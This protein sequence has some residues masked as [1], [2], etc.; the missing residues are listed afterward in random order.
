M[1][2]LVVLALGISLSFS[3]LADAQ[4]TTAPLRGNFLWIQMPHQ[5]QFAENYPQNALK[6]H[7]A[8]SATLDCRVG[9]DEHRH[10]GIGLACTML[11]ETPEGMGFGD[12]ALRVSRYLR[13]ASITTAGQPTSGRHLTVTLTFEAAAPRMGAVHLD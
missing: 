2:R 13:I 4:D 11:S 7:L 10:D 3:V 8:G 6:Q 9:S 12:A 5:R 1:Q